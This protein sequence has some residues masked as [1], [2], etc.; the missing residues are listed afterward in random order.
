MLLEKQ[1]ETNDIAADVQ[2]IKSLQ[3]PTNEQKMQLM[4]VYK[5]KY[6]GYIPSDIQGALKGHLDDDVAEEM[7]QESIR[8][9]GGVYDFELANVST[10][11]FNKYKDKL[12]VAGSSAVGTDD[13]KKANEFITTYTN[14]G[15]E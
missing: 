9:Q 3:N 15:T 7:L 13:H 8:Y 10:E 11:L 1:N 4:E 12:I 14:E 5:Q 2:V 6:D